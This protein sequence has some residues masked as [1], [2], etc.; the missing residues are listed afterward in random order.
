MEPI[1]AADR[2]YETLVH[3]AVH[4]HEPTEGRTFKKLFNV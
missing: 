4:F 1:E 3:E 2:L